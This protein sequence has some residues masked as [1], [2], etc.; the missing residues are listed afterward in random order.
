MLRKLTL[1]V[2]LAL[3]SLLSIQA[4]ISKDRFRELKLVQGDSVFIRPRRFELFP[5]RIH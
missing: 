5:N 3:A 2:L 1:G 4:E